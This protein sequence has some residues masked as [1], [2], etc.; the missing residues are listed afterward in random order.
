MLNAI[1]LE[2]IA[3]LE[4]ELVAHAPEIEA[5][6][7]NELAKLAKWLLDY[8][9]GKIGEK[10]TMLAAPAPESVAVAVNAIVDAVKHVSMG[11]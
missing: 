4:K 7:M 11:S 3:L 1:L 5:A 8:V 9:N 6:V 2:A 10:P